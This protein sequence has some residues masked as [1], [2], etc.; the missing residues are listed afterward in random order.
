MVDK[1][2]DYSK[3]PKPGPQSSLQQ[4]SPRGTREPSWILG[5]GS[6]NVV[7]SR[8]G[9]ITMGCLPKVPPWGG[10]GEFIHAKHSTKMA[11]MLE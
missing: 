3:P 5:D 8:L 1:T 10:A 2:K 11:L 6:W 7:D 9:G 4:C